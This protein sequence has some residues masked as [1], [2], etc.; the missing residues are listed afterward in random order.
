MANRESHSFLIL[1]T[2]TT[3]ASS[4]GT[5]PSKMNKRKATLAVIEV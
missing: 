5:Q 1:P 3:M 4:Q 2:D